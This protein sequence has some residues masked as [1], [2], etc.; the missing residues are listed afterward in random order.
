MSVIRNKN[1][2]PVKFKKRNK[3]KNYNYSL[4]KFGSFGFFLKNEFRFEFV[5][6][7]LLKKNLKN[8]FINK[9]KYKL[10]KKYWI[11]LSK[12]Y[13]ISNK[14]KNARMGKGKGAFVRWAVRLKKYFVFFEL[15]GLNFFR[16][17]LLFSF[18]KKKLGVEMFLLKNKNQQH[19]LWSKKNNSLF[20]IKRYN[21]F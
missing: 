11:F 9:I 14:T 3:I 8:L 20:F 5:Y 12:N 21:L 4:L 19:P 17:N 10:T 1:I 6:L 15:T 13:P 18:F 2:L 7:A 16:L